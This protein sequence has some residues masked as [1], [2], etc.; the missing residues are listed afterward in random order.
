[1][2]HLGRNGQARVRPFG[3]WRFNTVSLPAPSRCTGCTGTHE[4][5]QM[6][7]LELA[8]LAMRYEAH[9]SRFGAGKGQP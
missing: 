6:H 3:K 2:G 7:T 8:G 1:M 5:A 4:I 9:L